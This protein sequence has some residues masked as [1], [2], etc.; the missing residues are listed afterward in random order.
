MSQQ[1]S[2]VTRPTPQ[3]DTPGGGDTLWRLVSHLS[4]NHLSLTGGADGVAA[5]KEILRLYGGRDPEALEYH[6]D[7]LHGLEVRPAVLR[8]GEDAWRGFCRGTDILLTVDETRLDLGTAYV[9]GTVLS[10]FLGLY[11][12]ANLFTRLT[13]IS[14]QRPGTCL[15]WP[16]R[17]SHRAL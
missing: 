11:A 3:L 12:A 10:H 7:G 15:S 4:L 6:L 14:L 2:P 13:M 8:V 17:T 1:Q 9:F 16:P 5:L